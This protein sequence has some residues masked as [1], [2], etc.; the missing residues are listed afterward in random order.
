MDANTHKVII[1][2]DHQ[3]LIDGIIEL[4]E[5]SEG[6]Q[7][8]GMANNANQAMDL[9]KKSEP[10]FVIT[11]INMPGKKGTE[12]IAEIKDLKKEIKVIALSM[13]EEK[14]IIKDVLKAGADGYVLKRSTK[15]ELVEAIDKVSNGEVFVSN[16]ITKM[17]VDDIRYPSIESLLSEREREIIKL[18][19]AEKTN[20]QI[21]EILFISEKTVETHK[22][23]IFRKTETS[24]AV[25]LTKFAIEHGLT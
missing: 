18:I 19:V 17:L 23:N 13:H 20:K 4:L 11:D 7:V 22:T 8:I 14:H 12:L 10:Q 25:G 6:C 5:N 16:Q 2:D 24:S 15:E 3:I 9:I 1:V 21:A